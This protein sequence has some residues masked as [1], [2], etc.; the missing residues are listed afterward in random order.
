MKFN[1]KTL[2]IIASILSIISCNNNKTAEIKTDD[3]N[4]KQ[5]EVHKGKNADEAIAELKYGNNRFLENKFINTNYK[6]QIEATKGG[7]HPHSFILTCIDSR[8]PPEIIFDQGIGNIFVSRLA[9]NIEDDDV[10]GSMEFA[11]KVKHTKLFVVL[12]HSHCG[13]VKGAIDN[14]GLEHLTQLTNK[15][16]PAINPQKTYPL[17]DEVE[18]IVSRKNVNL[19]IE[20]ILKNSATLR[21][22]VEEKEIKIVGAF[23]DISNGEVEFFD[24]IKNEK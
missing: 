23:Y 21:L 6:A 12:G 4:H 1:K 20:Q 16:K 17:E 22:M 9:G 7:Q 5:A 10:L 2:T 18:D 15:I 11:A 24:E 14:A 8:V 3:K 19:T 13:A